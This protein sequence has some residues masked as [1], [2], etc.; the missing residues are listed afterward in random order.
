LLEM[1]SGVGAGDCEGIRG[2][3]RRT[4]EENTLITF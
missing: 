4:P 3:Q 2:I 1:H